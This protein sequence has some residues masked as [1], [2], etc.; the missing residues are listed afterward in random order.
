LEPLKQVSKWVPRS[1]AR[2]NMSSSCQSSTALGHVSR[3]LRASGV[4]I[5]HMCR[6]GLADSD[7]LGLSVVSR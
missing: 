1:D 3:Q 5:A 6:R 2:S 4:P 7:E